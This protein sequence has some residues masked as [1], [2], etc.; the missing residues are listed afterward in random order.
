MT[1]GG[2]WSNAPPRIGHP[3]P[4]QTPFWKGFFLHIPLP[5]GGTEQCKQCSLNPPPSRKPQNRGGGGRN[6]RGGGEEEGGAAI[7]LCHFTFFCLF[8][9]FLR[10][11]SCRGRVLVDDDG[12][13]GGEGAVP[14]IPTPRRRRQR[15]GAGQAMHWGGE[16]EG[17][18]ARP[19]GR[20]R[21]PHPQSPKWGR[22][23][24]GPAG[25][26]WGVPDVSGILILFFLFFFLISPPPF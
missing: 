9:T 3:P 10:C 14:P 18:S 22:G 15:W 11:F 23:G 5:G 21:S 7:I 13:W 25:G 19:E 8:E 2:F 1:P 12:G 16:G 6:A 26:G 17:G 20:L 24:G 4:P